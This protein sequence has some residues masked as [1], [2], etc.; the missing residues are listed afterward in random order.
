MEKNR[1]FIGKL[2]LI[3]IGL[4]LLKYFFDWSIF[5]A[6]ESERGKEVVAYIKNIITYIWNEIFSK[7]S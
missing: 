6:I 5:D 7:A 4:A 3:I 1:G 2:I